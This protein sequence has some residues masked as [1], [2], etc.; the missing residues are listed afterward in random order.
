MFGD[1]RRRHAAES[2]ADHVSPG[3]DHDRRSG[4]VG[5]SVVRVLSNCD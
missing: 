4:E 1:H 5:S 2:R 3:S